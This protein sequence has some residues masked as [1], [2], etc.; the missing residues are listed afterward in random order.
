MNN[1]IV[2]VCVLVNLTVCVCL[3]VMCV[4]VCV[5]VCFVAKIS[6]SFIIILCLLVNVSI[7][8]SDV[9]GLVLCRVESA[10]QQN[11]IMDVFFDDWAALT[12]DDGSFGSKA[13]NHLKVCSSDTTIFSS[14]LFN[15]TL[16]K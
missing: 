13:D 8:V 3:C 1:C 15:F 16:F 9:A 4:C 6:V 7:S 14:V 10:L 12:I 11:E 2:T 5:C